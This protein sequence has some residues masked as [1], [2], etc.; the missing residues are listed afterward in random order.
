MPLEEV[1][2]WFVVPEGQLGAFPLIFVHRLCL[3]LYVRYSMFASTRTET[4]AQTP[5]DRKAPQRAPAAA[6]RVQQDS[7]FIG[8]EAYRESLAGDKRSPL[9]MRALSHVLA[10]LLYLVL[11]L[12]TGLFDPALNWQLWQEVAQFAWTLLVFVAIAYGV[13]RRH[14]RPWGRTSYSILH[15][16]VPQL[17]MIKIIVQSGLNPPWDLVLWF[18]M[19]A[20]LLDPVTGPWPDVFSLATAA[21]PASFKY[22][23]AGLML[24]VAIHLAL[25]LFGWTFGNGGPN[26]KLLVLRVFGASRASALI[27][28]L[29]ADAWTRYGTYFTIDDPGFARYRY[30]MF[31]VSTLF[32]WLVASLFFLGAGLRAGLIFLAIV[33]FFDW[34]DLFRRRPASD[35]AGALR[36]I[37]RTLARPW[38]LDSR[39]ADLR[40]VAYMNLW[41]SVVQE[42]VRVSDVVLFDLRGYDDSRGGSAWEVGLLFDTFAL[43]RIVVLHTYDD[44][45]AVEHMLQRTW[46]TLWQGS[47]NADLPD[48]VVELVCI[49]DEGDNV[50]THEVQPLMSRLLCLTRATGN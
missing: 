1:V 16:P 46:S 15:T 9:D 49:H 34:Y 25:V 38:R 11:P 2:S 4:P 3:V 8:D 41:K 28:D 44:R 39:Y 35:L 7:L 37:E 45:E 18:C 40:M 21:Q 20:S 27:F 22:F 42:F 30:R 19:A 17:R 26:P 14:F 24:A 32:T 12:L 50:D 23:L 10:A 36:R 5:P 6:L 48:P 31:Q 33:F 29:L 13:N 47:P 43:H